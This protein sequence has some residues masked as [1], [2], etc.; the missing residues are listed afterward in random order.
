MPADDITKLQTHKDDSSHIEG[1]RIKNKDSI[2]SLFFFPKHE[3]SFATND[4]AYSEIDRHVES[5]VDSAVSPRR[6]QL[7]IEP[8]VASLVT[9]ESTY[10]E[11]ELIEVTYDVSPDDNMAPG[12]YSWVALF[13]HDAVKFSQPA[14]AVYTYTHYGTMKAIVKLSTRFLPAL[15]SKY[16]VVM[17]LDSSDPLRILGMSDAFDILPN[18]AA[19][20][21]DESQYYEGEL[22]DVTYTMNEMV[23]R[24]E[25]GFVWVGLFADDVQDYSL[26]P[27]SHSDDYWWWAVD[28]TGTNS[29]SSRNLPFDSKVK[30]V[31]VIRNSNPPRILGVSNSFDVLQNFAMLST[32][33]TQYF[34]GEL[35][36]VT[37]NMNETVD[38]REYGF[39]WVGLYAHNVSDY[40][41]PPVALP[42]DYWTV[43]KTGT[44]SFSSRNLP[45]DSKFKVVMIVA[46]STPPPPLGFLV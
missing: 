5:D 46:G 42:Y 40:S 12:F 43:A 45:F 7:S 22:I 39:A 41:L 35:I 3:Q 44:I 6:A 8:A 31:M 9:D 19:L 18:S 24:V 29:F 30:A 13:P 21:T 25:Y 23:D 1:D 34:E 27:L 26:P 2:L 20:T 38:I 11:G 33:E 32:D 36:E 10:Y 4:D 15:N 37:Y 28:N 14:S 16:K 17:A